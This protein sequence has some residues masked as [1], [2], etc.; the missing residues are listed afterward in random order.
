MKKQR[1]TTNQIFHNIHCYIPKRVTSWRGQFRV[2]AP[3]Q[4][5]SFQRNVAAVHDDPL[6]TLC[7]V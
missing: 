3:L 1:I 6:E 7:S 2:F 4:H 5:S